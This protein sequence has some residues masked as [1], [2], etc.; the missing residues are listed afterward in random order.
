MKKVLCSTLIILSFAASTFAATTVA[1][2]TGA[3]SIRGGADSGT[4][5]AA[6]TPLIKFSTGVFGLVNSTPDATA[7]TAAGYLIA[8]RHSTGSK[9]FAT[10]NTV[11][12]IYWKQVTAGTD[13]AARL[14]ADVGALDTS[15]TF[16]AGQGWT[17]Y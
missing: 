8:T 9:N 4:A 3:Q 13:T 10:A 7:K 6:A 14:L 2:T 12:N 17:S 15:A 11:T 16:A 5:A 1:T